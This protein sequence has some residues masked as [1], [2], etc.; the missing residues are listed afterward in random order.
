MTDKPELK[1]PEIKFCKNGYEIRAD[2][3]GYAKDYLSQEYEFKLNKYKNSVKTEN[4]QVVHTVEYP[5]FPGL[6]NILDAAE[7]FLAFVNNNSK[8]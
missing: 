8:K 2:L 1:T 4:G 6:N 3:I 5:Q 7:K